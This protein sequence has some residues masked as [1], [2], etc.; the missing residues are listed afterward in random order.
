MH[1]SKADCEASGS[2]TQKL[3]LLLGMLIIITVNH[4]LIVY[5]VCEAVGTVTGHVTNIINRLSNSR[6]K[7]RWQNRGLG[8]LS[9]MLQL[10]TGKERVRIETLTFLP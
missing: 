5:E 10:G 4:L 7:C 6:R 2:H 9:W 1:Q 3:F 8:S